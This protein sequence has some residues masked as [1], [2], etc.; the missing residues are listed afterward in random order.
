MSADPPGE[1]PKSVYEVAEAAFDIAEQAGI[2]AAAVVEGEAEGEELKRQR[3][4]ALASTYDSSL[5][6]SGKTDEEID[7]QKHDE[8]LLVG[9]AAIVTAVMVAHELDAQHHHG[10]DISLHHDAHH[11]HHGGDDSD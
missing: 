6:K 7:K 11:V 5:A 4:A 2:Q 9:G 10:E 3:D 8:A 1:A